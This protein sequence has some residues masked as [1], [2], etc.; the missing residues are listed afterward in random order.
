MGTQNQQTANDTDARRRVE[1]IVSDN[2]R[3][4]WKP[5]KTMAPYCPKCGHRLSGNNSMIAPYRCKC[6]TWEQ[7][8][9]DAS[10]FIKADR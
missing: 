10:F 3:P 4:D 1:Q 7:S 9:I 8:R 2:I 5:T 6:G